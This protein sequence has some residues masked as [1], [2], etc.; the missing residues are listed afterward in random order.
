MTTLQSQSQSH[1]ALF[2]PVDEDS[3]LFQICFYYGLLVVFVEVAVPLLFRRRLR[4]HLPLNVLPQAPPVLSDDAFQ[5][6]KTQLGA[7]L[8]EL[9]RASSAA[10]TKKLLRRKSLGLSGEKK[11]PG[12]GSTA[13]HNRNG[14]HEDAAN[15]PSGL[16]P[17]S[18]T[19]LAQ[20]STGK[21]AKSTSSSAWRA[22]EARSSHQGGAG[23][24]SADLPPSKL[25]QPSRSYFASP[26]A[27]ESAERAT[28]S[29]PSSG[30]RRPSEKRRL[31]VGG[32][33]KSSSISDTQQRQVQR[34]MRRYSWQKDSEAEVDDDDLAASKLPQPSFSYSSSLR[35]DVEEASETTFVSAH[36]SSVRKQRTQESHERFVSEAEPQHELH[37]EEFIDF[38][39]AEPSPSQPP[40]RSIG[41]FAQSEQ[42][43]FDDSDEEFLTVIRRPRSPVAMAPSRAFTSFGNEHMDVERTINT[44]FGGRPLGGGAAAP[45]V[46][47]QPV[48]TAPA[49]PMPAA[50]SYHQANMYEQHRAQAQ[51]LPQQQQQ[52]NQFITS[53]RESADARN[54]H[55]E[56]AVGASN[57]REVAR[58]RTPKIIRKIAFDEEMMA[59]AATPNP[60]AAAGE[61]RKRSMIFSPEDEAQDFSRRRTRL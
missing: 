13:R 5:Q 10:K 12:D 16:R 31:S 50:A 56:D 6:Q 51:A 22:R 34:E 8:R 43:I 57:Y 32:S 59:L 23:V 27:T 33:A 15:P 54:Y 44:A 42:S 21:S 17:P 53:R 29:A 38:Y 2:L 9:Q 41:R 46:H 20:K 30:E 28:A 18:S 61:K 39:P 3:L 52:R 49:P 11:A 19:H 48:A 14:E 60:D 4:L 7:K 24:A 25:Q 45:A 1:E 37:E 40:Q 55:Q 26:A 47:Y 35:R 58:D 36:E